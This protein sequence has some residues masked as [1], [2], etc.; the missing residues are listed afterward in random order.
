MKTNDDDTRSVLLIVDFLRTLYAI[1]G[2][3]AADAGEGD[4]VIEGATTW[5]DHVTELL[6]CFR[7][8]YVVEPS[9]LPNADT[10]EHVLST[11]TADAHLCR[12]VPFEL[13]PLMETY[14][15][16][17]VPPEVWGPRLW[18]LLHALAHH[19]PQHVARVLRVL[20]V[21]IP[22]RAC[23]ADLS[24]WLSS[25]PGPHARVAQ[26]YVVAL[27]NHVNKKLNKNVEILFYS[28]VV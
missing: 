20:T 5:C 23:G 25:H 7:W 22:C 1:T 26:A 28:Y 16:G 27:H 12:L 15:G 6:A 19:E 17:D 10:F 14:L 11:H 8:V 13:E 21:L 24:R 9:P 2:A 3:H 18:S 4:T